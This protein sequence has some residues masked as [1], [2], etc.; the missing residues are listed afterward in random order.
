MVVREKKWIGNTGAGLT[1]A[2]ALIFGWSVFG[3]HRLLTFVML[4]PLLG[5]ILLFLDYYVRRLEVKDGICHYRTMFGK[6]TSCSLGD[7]QEIV[8]L[9]DTHICFRKAEGEKVLFQLEA[10]ME[11]APEFVHF[12]LTEYPEQIIYKGRKSKKYGYPEVLRLTVKDEQG[13]PVLMIG[14]DYC[15]GVG[16]LGKEHEF[17]MQEIKKIIRYGN[18]PDAEVVLLGDQDTRKAAFRMNMENGSAAL[19]FFRD[20]CQQKMTSE[21]GRLLPGFEIIVRPECERLSKKEFLLAEAEEIGAWASVPLVFFAMLSWLALDDYYDLS[22]LGLF[23]WTDGL[24]IW[25]PTLLLVLIWLAGKIAALLRFKKKN[26]KPLRAVCTI[27]HM[28]YLMFWLFMWRLPMSFCM[29]V[30]VVGILLVW[31]LYLPFHKE[32]RFTAFHKDKVTVP[33]FG[34]LFFLMGASDCFTEIY[35]VNKVPVHNIQGVLFVVLFLLVLL[36]SYDCE[37]WMTRSGR[38]LLVVMT[39]YWMGNGLPFLFSTG[40]IVHE[41]KVILETEYIPRYKGKASYYISV[42]LDETWM[43]RYRVSEELYWQVEIEDP[44]IF[45]HH[46]SWLSDYSYFHLPETECEYLNVVRN[47]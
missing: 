7:I 25:L 3:D 19:R 24:A 20:C 5:G 23:D 1:A 33:W 14:D 15:R 4:L 22:P 47:K 11:H 37:D 18:L 2:S 26:H 32:M 21:S 40:E 43:K 12:L 30:S 44:I 45:C 9:E 17:P 39:C 10:N 8:I 42:P 28:V 6:C 16:L 27:F 29:K 41:E 46:E 38:L 34:P 31:L 36:F 35:V 13:K